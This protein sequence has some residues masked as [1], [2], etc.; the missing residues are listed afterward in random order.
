MLISTR[1]RADK[2]DFMHTC[3]LT[4]FYALE[5][6]LTR[7][8]SHIHTYTHTYTPTYTY[9]L[10]HA[11]RSKNEHKKGCRLYT[12]LPCRRVHRSAARN[13]L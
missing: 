2:Y 9:T 11:H 13:C 10:S 4:S 7:I 6:I 3:T 8:H 12:D 5:N 1:V